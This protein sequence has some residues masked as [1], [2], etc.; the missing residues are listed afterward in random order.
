MKT[1]KKK[2]HQK[3]MIKRKLKFQDYKNCFE[4]SQ[5]ENGI[6]YLEKNKTDDIKEFIKNHKL[7]LKN[8]TKI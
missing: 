2:A 5:I 1:K 4:A 7:I 8:T 6:N 3:C